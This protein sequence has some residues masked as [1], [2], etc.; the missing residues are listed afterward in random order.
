MKVVIDCNILV[1]AA[2]SGGTCGRVIGEA[3]R[4]HKIIL[5]QPILDEYLEI[6]HRAKHAQYANNMLTIIK[7]IEQVS[8][9]VAPSNVVFGIRDPDDEVYLATAVAGGAVVVTGNTKDF[10]KPKYGPVVI[11][12]PRMFIDHVK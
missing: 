7:E 6:S 9:M 11:L 12:T 2:R 3:L 1:S 8:M 5:S 10:T 4:H